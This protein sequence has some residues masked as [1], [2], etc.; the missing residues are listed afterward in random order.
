MEA[1]LAE[2]AQDLLPVGPGNILLKDESTNRFRRVELAGYRMARHAVTR[3]RYDAVMGGVPREGGQLPVVDV[4][5]YEAIRYCNALSSQALLEP[6]YTIDSAWVTWNALANGYRLPSEA[7]WEYACRAGSSAARYG[8]LDAIAWYAGNAGGSVHEVGG[9]LPN[10]LGLFDMLGNTWEWCWDLYDPAVYGE[11]RVFR[12][13]GW[14]DG[15]NACRA[16]CRRKSHPAFHI[17]DLGFRVVRSG[18]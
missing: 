10:V 13:G 14:M 9:K 11:Y 4:S 8:E 6:C 18:L 5:W 12:G 3:A 7:E 16:S 1:L 15:P 2:I 17:D